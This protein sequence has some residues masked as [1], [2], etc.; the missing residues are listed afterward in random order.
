MPVRMQRAAVKER[1][2]Y[3]FDNFKG[4]DFTTSPYKAA[5]FRATQSKNLIY[6]NGTVRKRNGWESLCKLSGKINGLFSFEIEG[7][8]VVLCYAGTQFYRLNYDANRKRFNAV[9]ITGSCT[10][11]PAALDTA[12]LAERRLQVLINGNKAYIVG[13]GDYLVFGKWSGGFELRRVYN[14]EDTYIPTTTINIDADGVEDENRGSLDGVNLLSPY[15]KN[16]FLG[17]DA[18]SGVW[19]VDTADLDTQAIDDQSDVD[20]RLYT[21][22]GDTAVV[23]HISNRLGDKENLYY[24]GD[25]AT[26]VGTIDYAA[27]KITLNRNTKPQEADTSNIIVTFEKSVAGQDDIVANA[28]ISA[29]FGGG[30][31]SNRLFVSGNAGNKAV[32]VW[33]EMYD[34]TYFPDNN[35][36]KLGSDSSAILGYVR[37][38]DGTLL[39]LKERNGSDSTAYYITGTDTEQNDYRGNPEFITTFHKKAGNISDTIYAKDATASLNGDSLILS[40]HGVKGLQVYENISIESYRVQERGRNINGKLLESKNLSDA[41]GFVFEDKYFLAVDGAV[42]IADSR[43]TFQNEEDISSSFNYEWWYWEGVNARVF[44][45]IDGRLYFGTPDGLICRFHDDFADITYQ[46]TEGGDLSVQYSDNKI[47][48]GL[49]LDSVLAEK[50]NLV[51]TQ[52]DVF[53]L[54]FDY[55][56]ILGIDDDGYLSVA[57][58]NINKVYEGIKVYADRNINTGLEVDTEYVIGDVDLD[59]LRFAL[60]L[61]GEQVIPTATGFRLCKRVSGKP[62]FITNIDHAAE[63]FQVREFEGADILD[64]VIYNYGV[65]SE[66][67]ATI[68][69]KHNIRA[70]WYTPIYD[71]GTNMFSKTLFNVTIATEPLSKGAITAG[72][73][74]RNIE[75]DFSTRGSRA[76]DFND[77]DFY[78]FSFE[79]SFASSYTLR[80]KERN[81]NYI[82]LRWVSDNQASCAVNSITIRY[83]VNQINRG[84]R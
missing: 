35:Y 7:E 24:D 76:F 2:S 49:Q 52:G 14:N 71:L 59:N 45:E 58:A 46:D 28:T 41:C 63:E 33:S 55:A 26:V 1:K 83:K 67:L 10:Y 80:A 17:V 44:C 19:T 72:Y 61:N 12:R 11:A 70:E 56:D 4:V 6:K 47:S 13:A 25:D 40:R 62:L 31:A 9:N 15:R 16:E 65:P 68:I 23:I 32:H 48:F 42:Y 75:K 38:S 79:S 66:L 34:F 54:Y 3:T 74:T 81:F 73:Q 57:E 84:V 60:F 43:F 5:A 51:I 8:K 37:V 39:A 30:G 29:V 20:I 50:D 82:V 21:Y 77:I 69:Y 78:D 18:E 53:A 36:D 27:G 22:D 64:L